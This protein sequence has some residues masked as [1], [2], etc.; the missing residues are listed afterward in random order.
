MLKC[1]FSIVVSLTVA[2][3]VAL[4][5]SCSMQEREEKTIT[6]SIQPQ[7]YILESIV[8]PH[9]KVRCLLNSGGDPETYDPSMSHLMNVEK[10]MAYFRVGQIGFED[11]IIDRIKL[12]RPDLPIVDTSKGITYIKGT[13][14]DSESV[15]PHVWASV[16]NMRI[17]AK[18]IYEA[19]CE[20]DTAHAKTFKANYEKLTA[21]L[22]SLDRAIQINLAAKRDN[23]I[24]VWHPSLSYFARDYGLKQ[25]AVGAE[26]KEISPIDLKA[27]LDSITTSGSRI[28]IAE[29]GEERTERMA[30]EDLGLPVYQMNLQTYDWDKQMLDLG[31]AIGGINPVSSPKM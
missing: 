25:I 31:R 9:I 20:M 15:D 30:R 19:V 11:A 24:V 26:H 10:S 18:N 27:R 2:A 12:S 7:K 3:I 14:G 29:P 21:H 22:D 6:V 23:A 13:H 1:K 28:F 5:L 16:A 4:C 17:M 8:G